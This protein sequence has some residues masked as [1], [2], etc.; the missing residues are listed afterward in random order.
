MRYA[1]YWCVPGCR[2]QV[3]PV[4]WRTAVHK[5]DSHAT[6][7]WREMNSNPRSPVRRTT[8]FETPL[9][10]MRRA[11]AAFENARRAAAAAPSSCRSRS[12]ERRT[13]S[14]T[15]RSSGPPDR[16]YHHPF[17]LLTALSF[18]RVR[19]ISCSCAVA[20]SR[21]RGLHLSQPSHFRGSV[22]AMGA[23]TCF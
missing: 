15:R 3:T 23:A 6:L 18:F 7:C 4:V 16:R 2:N 19:F 5:S 21:S 9:P 22:Q 1:D 10:N 20:L 8:L 11:T 12:D 17:A 13:H 14:P